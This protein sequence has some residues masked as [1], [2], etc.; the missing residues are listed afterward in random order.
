MEKM[1]CLLEQ[2]L[3][4]TESEVKDYKSKFQQKDTQLKEA[5]KAQAVAQK[6]VE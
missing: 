2:K 6:E 1:N 3:E 5:N 4:L